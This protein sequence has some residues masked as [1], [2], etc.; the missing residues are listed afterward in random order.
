MVLCIVGDARLLFTCNLLPAEILKEFQ[1][2]VEVKQAVKM[3]RQ[4]WQPLAVT[5]APVIDWPEPSIVR[6]VVRIILHNE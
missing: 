4:H 1:W 5:S 3:E 6:Q 2:F